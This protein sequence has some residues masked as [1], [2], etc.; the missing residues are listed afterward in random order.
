MNH[1]PYLLYE[2]AQEHRHQ[3]LAQAAARRLQQLVVS[4][5]KQTPRRFRLHWP[6]LGRRISQPATL[7]PLTPLG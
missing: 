6:R 2:L 3:R 5:T 4:S 7:P 1:N